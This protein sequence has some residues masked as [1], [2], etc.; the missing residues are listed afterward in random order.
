MSVDDLLK[1]GGGL[2]RKRCG[3]G[4]GEAV[5]GSESAFVERDEQPG[6]GAGHGAYP[7]FELHRSAHRRPR[8][9]RHGYRPHEPGTAE[10]R[11]DPPVHRHLDGLSAKRAFG[12]SSTNKLVRYYEGCTGLKTGYTSGAGF[13]ISATAKR[14]ELELIAVVLGAKTSKDRFATASTLLDWGFA[15]F[16]SVT[17]TPEEPLE[18]VPVTLVR[19]SA[20]G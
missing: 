18:S 8:H 16:Q 10:P 7:L 4:A 13:C 9:L 1:S 6:G 11:A 5:A 2:L 20:W 17:V 14:G 3:G 19:R 12:L 15:N